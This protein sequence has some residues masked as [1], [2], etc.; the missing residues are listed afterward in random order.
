MGYNGMEGSMN[1]SS[2]HDSDHAKRLS[3]LD[4]ERVGVVAMGS[5]RELATRAKELV[6]VAADTVRAEICEPEYVKEFVATLKHGASRGVMD[7]TCLNIVSQIYKLL[8]EERKLTVEFIHS[9]GVQSEAELRTY[10]ERGRS[11]EGVGPHDGAERCAAYLEAYLRAFPE[12]RETL[13]KRMGG[14]VAVGSAERV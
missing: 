13:V 2:A 11:V 4:K 1:G 9:L 3:A 5:R 14:L 12:Q 7:R 8:G 10:I 6:A